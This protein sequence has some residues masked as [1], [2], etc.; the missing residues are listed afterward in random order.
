MCTFY[1]IRK[2][3]KIASLPMTGTDC[4]LTLGEFIFDQ[5]G[6]V[7]RFNGPLAKYSRHIDWALVPIGYATLRALVD[8][9]LFCEQGTFDL[10]CRRFGLADSVT[11]PIL[12]KEIGTINWFIGPDAPRET[13]WHDSDLF[14]DALKLIQWG[15]SLAARCP[16]EFVAHQLQSLVAMSRHDLGQYVART[17]G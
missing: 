4:H 15:E 6:V 12:E 7:A 16:N 13:L 1:R 5:A 8:D 3:N 17:L 11:E 10:V 9:I 2:R 14:E